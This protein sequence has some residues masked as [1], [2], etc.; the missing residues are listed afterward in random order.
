MLARLT[1]HR[2]KALMLL[3]RIVA[4]HWTLDNFEE[5]R[6][7]V[8][9]TAS[10]EICNSSCRNCASSL[11]YGYHCIRQHDGQFTYSVLYVTFHD[12]INNFLNISLF[13]YVHKSVHR[14]STWF[15]PKVSVLIFLCTNW[16]RST[17]FM[18]IGTLV[19]TLAACPYLFQLDWLS[20]SFVYVYGRVF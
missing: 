3:D 15:V 12:A 9:K 18:Y 11:E 17:S 7:F 6:I 10:K 2:V 19:V 8:T 14:K 13:F 16:Q 4:F 20:Q 5:F 1:S